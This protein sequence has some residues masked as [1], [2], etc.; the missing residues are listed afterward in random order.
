MDYKGYT[1]YENNNGIEI[2]GVRD[3]DLGHIFDCGQSFRWLKQQD[4]SYIG[5]VKDKVS[6]IRFENGKLYISNSNFDDFVKIWY[7]YFDLGTD[8]GEIKKILCQKD[9]V[10]SQAIP[11]GQGI[12]LLRQDIWELIISF[13]ISANN[14]I[15]RIM[16]SVETL[17][18]NFGRKI[19]SEEGDFYSFP[20]PEALSSCPLDQIEICKAGFRCK[21]I[22][23]TSNMIRKGIVNLST[24][25]EMTTDE[26]RNELIKLSGVG[27]KVADCILLFSGTNFDVFPT[28]VWIKRIMEVLYFKREATLKEIDQY[29]KDHFGSLS[30][31]AQQYLFFFARETRIS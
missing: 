21:Y 26:A 31:Y 1:V 15:P 13:I 30:G 22:S 12:R 3:F 14:R 9:E 28:D 25:K 4:G 16:K 6:R 7:D 27:R 17:S 5:V 29:A 18:Q 23:N 19:S 8:Y 11:F 2:E 24:L 20:S 10:M